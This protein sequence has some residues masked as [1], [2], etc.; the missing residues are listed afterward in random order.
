MILAASAA[1]PAARAAAGATEQEHVR[2]AITIAKRT[3]LAR[4]CGG[5]LGP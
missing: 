2:P 3:K 1:A 5:E 4:R